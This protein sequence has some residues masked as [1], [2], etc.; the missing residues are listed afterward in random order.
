MSIFAQFAVFLD[1]PCLHLAVAVD[2]VPF[3]A[4]EL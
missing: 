2:L 4:L 1:M 3:E